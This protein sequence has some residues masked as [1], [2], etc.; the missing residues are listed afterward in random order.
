MPITFICFFLASLSIIGLPPL[1]GLWSKWYLIEGSLSFAYQPWVLVGVLLL[2]SLLNI[3]YLLS[4]PVQAF[5]GKAPA[6]RA[7]EQ[8]HRVAEEVPHSRFEAPFACLLGI[9]IPTL[10]CLYLF[11]FPYPFF[12][13]IQ[14][15][16]TGLGG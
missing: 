1:G 15:G 11:F 5:M 13:L 16:S 14:M 6:P 4:I 2:S 10:I 7:D 9:L 3:W 8:I 12:S